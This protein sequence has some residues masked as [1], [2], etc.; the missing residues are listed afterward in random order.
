M[1][2]Y[3]VEVLDHECILIRKALR[4]EEQKTLFEYIQENDKTPSLANKPKPMVPSPKT[5]ILGEDQP[6][7]F[8]KF[9]QMW[10][11]YRN[12]NKFVNI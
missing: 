6:S 10:R 3:E 8:Y 12:F 5:L 4:L 2:S 7:R 9:G 11:H 1:G